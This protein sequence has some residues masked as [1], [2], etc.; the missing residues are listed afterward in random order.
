MHESNISSVKP[1]A[2]HK[3]RRAVTERRATRDGA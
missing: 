3:E 2:K 1:Y